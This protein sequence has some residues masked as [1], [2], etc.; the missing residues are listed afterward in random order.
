MPLNFLPVS[1]TLIK[2]LSAFPL[3]QYHQIPQLIS[4][5]NSLDDTP[6]PTSRYIFINLKETLI[7]FPG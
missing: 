7:I 6:I 3:D 4:F 5:Q 2:H 1:F